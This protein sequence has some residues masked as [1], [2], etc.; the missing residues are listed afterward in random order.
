[1]KI[2]Q[3]SRVLKHTFPFN[4]I[5]ETIFVRQLA[6]YKRPDDF[7][8]VVWKDESLEGFQ[9]PSNLTNAVNIE[10]RFESG[11][12]ISGSTAVCSATYPIV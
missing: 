11:S 2:P 9:I 12:V 1:M 8:V 4:Y 10:L 3:Q 7:L 6:L 5:I